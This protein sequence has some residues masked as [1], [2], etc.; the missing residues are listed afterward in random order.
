MAILAILTHEALWINHQNLEY[1]HHYKFYTYHIICETPSSI[2]PMTKISKICNL[3]WKLV[4]FCLEF[5]VHRDY[6]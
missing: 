4:K 3:K 5:V 2:F 1:L 6:L